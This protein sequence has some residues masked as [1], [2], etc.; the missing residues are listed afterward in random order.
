MNL[1]TKLIARVKPRYRR[2]TAGL[3]R[4]MWARATDIALLDKHGDV[5]QTWE[6]PHYL[7]QE[8]DGEISLDLKIDLRDS[9]DAEKF[10][11]VPS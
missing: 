4:A 10:E 6:V 11:A 9:Q 7:R 2:Q 1:P 5:L 8:S 3:T